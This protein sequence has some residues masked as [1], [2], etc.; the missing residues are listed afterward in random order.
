M[1]NKLSRKPA[2]RIN[3]HKAILLTALK[4]NENQNRFYCTS[5][6]PTLENPEQQQYESLDLVRI[7]RNLKYKPIIDEQV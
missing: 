4:R 1:L 5:N 2:N 6:E 7:A 3:L